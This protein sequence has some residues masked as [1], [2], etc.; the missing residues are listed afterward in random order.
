MGDFCEVFVNSYEVWRE[1]D[2]GR[3]TVN[4]EGFEKNSQ[5]HLFPF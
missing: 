1:F 5:M 4:A 3:S 2:A